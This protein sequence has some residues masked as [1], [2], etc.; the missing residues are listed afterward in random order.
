MRPN[1][2]PNS[3]NASILQF[4]DRTAG[5]IRYRAFKLALSGTAEELAAQAIGRLGT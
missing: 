2:Y 4:W 3:S 1:I 5:D